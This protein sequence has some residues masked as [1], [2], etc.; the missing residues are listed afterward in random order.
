M[1]IDVGLVNLQKPPY[2]ISPEEKRPSTSPLSHFRSPVLLCSVDLAACAVARAAAAVSRASPLIRRPRRLICRS[3]SPS[4]LPTAAA[5]EIQWK[6]SPFFGKALDLAA[7]AASSSAGW[8]RR[9]GQTNIYSV[10]VPNRYWPCFLSKL[11][12]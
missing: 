2:V 3:S 8:A 7:A 9:R 12:I 11:G 10:E 6:V 5:M 1:E 4:F